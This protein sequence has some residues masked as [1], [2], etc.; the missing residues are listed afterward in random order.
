MVSKHKTISTF[1]HPGN[2]NQVDISTLS[3]M[4]NHN[5]V[6]TIVK[7]FWF[8]WSEKPYETICLLTN[9]KLDGTNL[10]NR[11]ISPSYAS[12]PQIY[13]HWSF[14]HSESQS[15]YLICCIVHFFH[16]MIDCS[17]KPTRRRVTQS[18]CHGGYVPYPHDAQCDYFISVNDILINVYIR[19]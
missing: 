4:L 7:L 6:K 14:S 11:K 15:E 5:P 8:W 1:V 16:L 13:L 17:S 3:N 10:T 9:H 18:A 2:K 12:S 19:I